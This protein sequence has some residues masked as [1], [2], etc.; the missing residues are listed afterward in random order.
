MMFHYEGDSSVTVV[1]STA[2]KYLIKF[3]LLMPELDYVFGCLL[4]VFLKFI[5]KNSQ[6]KGPFKKNKSLLS[7]CRTTLFHL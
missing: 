6:I 5:T 4:F 7:N 1:L 3:V 2:T